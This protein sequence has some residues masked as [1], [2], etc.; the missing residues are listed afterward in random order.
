[1]VATGTHRPYHFLTFVVLEH[2]RTAHRQTV[3]LPLVN[4][5]QI[6]RLLISCVRQA[7]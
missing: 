7:P 3:L 6:R 2:G 1:M 5:S 4:L